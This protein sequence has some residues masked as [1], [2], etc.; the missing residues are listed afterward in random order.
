MKKVTDYEQI[1][2]LITKYMTAKTETNS[3]LIADDYREEISQGNLY[4]QNWN[5]GLLIFRQRKDFFRGNYYVILDTDRKPNIEWPETTIME[6]VFRPGRSRYILDYWKDMGFE[7]IFERMRMTRLPE[8]DI[9][10]LDSQ[11][12]SVTADEAEDILNECFDYRTAC[13][14]ERKEIEADAEESRFLSRRSD[15]GDLSAML[16]VSSKKSYYEIRQL[17]VRNQFRGSGL[18]DQ[19]TQEFT[20]RFGDKKCRVWVRKDFKETRKMYE[21]N[22]FTSDGWTSSVI[23]RNT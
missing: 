5:S 23:I 22:G 21:K 19:L 12:P 18:A 15:E 10:T 20:Q 4:V 14:P 16:R 9:S 8:T 13:L 17:C 11:I 6:I 1:S 7:Q 2:A 3:S